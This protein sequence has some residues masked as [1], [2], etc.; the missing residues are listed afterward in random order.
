MT[1]REP[2]R[3]A[4]RMPVC[5]LRQPI[6]GWAL[7]AGARRVRKGPL[8]GPRRRARQRVAETREVAESRRLGAPG[9][10]RVPVRVLARPRGDSRLYHRNGKRL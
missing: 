3:H 2:V 1:N 8:T 5:G 6:F 9:S 4:V 10:D 7:A